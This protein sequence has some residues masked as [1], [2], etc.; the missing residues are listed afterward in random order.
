MKTG[1]VQILLQ[2]NNVQDNY[3]K[4]KNA[5]IDL[6][7]QGAKLIIFPQM[8]LIGFPAYDFWRHNALLLQQDHYLRLLAEAFPEEHL[9]IGG[10]KKNSNTKPYHVIFHLYNGDIQHT[11]IKE[12]LIKED[13]LNESKYFIRKKQQDNVLQIDDKKIVINF[14][15]EVSDKSFQANL[16]LYFTAL[17]AHTYFEKRATINKNLTRIKKKTIV[18]NVL[19]SEGHILFPGGSWI[20]D[21]AAK[22]IEN[23]P[24]FEEKNIILDCNDV[25]QNISD[26]SYKEKD[27]K[28]VYQALLFGIRQYCKQTGFQKAVIGLSGG[29]DSAV[30]AVLG[31]HALGKDN[32]RAIL[33]PSQFSTEHSLSDAKKLAENL[34]IQYDIVSIHHLFDKYEETL[35]PIFKNLPFDITEE[36]IQA[37]IR[38]NLVM[39]L[40]NKFNS[41]VL[42]TSNKS[43]GLVGYGTLYGDIVGALGVILDLYKTEVY[44]LAKFINRNH[45]IIPTHIIT[46]S[47]S[48]ELRPGQKDSDA[49]PEYTVLDKILKAFVEEFKTVDEICK[50]GYKQDEVKDVVRKIYQNDY[51]K[52]QCPP[53][54]IISGK[55]R[56]FPLLFM[57][58]NS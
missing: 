44:E 2:V 48:A 35:N 46:K 32:V 7:N 18:L 22:P 27:I 57:K 26:D 49:L 19:S 20:I 38:G 31:V 10:V 37:R 55:G 39:A 34:S 42:N 1:I 3:L 24:V 40:A 16:V 41:I 45:E 53:P 8:S 47:P 23:L 50:M 6:K 43:E 52:Y 36:N 21:E 54:L 14:E 29:I 28:F 56:T 9:L 17:P 33:M 11:F 12:N 51:K 25:V 58:D 15:D 5:I 4:I 13:W 30:V